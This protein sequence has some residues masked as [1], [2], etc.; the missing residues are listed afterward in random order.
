MDAN[1]DAVCSTAAPAY[2]IDINRPSCSL[3]FVQVARNSKMINNIPPTT[4]VAVEIFV[5]TRPVV[6]LALF[7]RVDASRVR[8]GDDNYGFP[9]AL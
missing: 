7:R 8:S 4:Q 9:V 1:R 6:H 3:F 2:N 5:V